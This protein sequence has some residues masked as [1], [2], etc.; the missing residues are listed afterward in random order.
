MMVPVN[1][2]GEVVNVTEADQFQPAK[3]AFACGFFAC[4]IARSMA[5]PGQTPTLNVQQIITSAEQWYTQYDGSDTATNID[6]M[7]SAQEYELLGHIGLHYQAIAE[8]IGQVKKWLM[9]GYPV[10]LA[11][12]EASVHDL[13]LDGAN[14]YPWNPINT[15]IV[16]ATGVNESGNLLVRDS[17]NISRK[18]ADE[19]ALGRGP[20]T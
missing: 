17:A 12:Q 20:R 1:S 9:A 11:V 15:H 10:L 3:T 5:K 19:K 8:D 16:L 18:A 4:A 13:G 6:G 7:T 2:K 14:P